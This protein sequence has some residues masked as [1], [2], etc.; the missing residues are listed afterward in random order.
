M[1]DTML[2]HSVA[3]R[4]AAEAHSAI[5]LAR[6]TLAIDDPRRHSHCLARRVDARIAR[7]DM[8][9]LIADVAA[10]VDAIDD[11]LRAAQI[12]SDGPMLAPGQLPAWVHQ[13]VALATIGG[14]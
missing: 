10:D 11:A 1:S 4:R 9:E 5:L 7:E 2:T 3:L 6:E 13:A 14:R 8:E 12:W